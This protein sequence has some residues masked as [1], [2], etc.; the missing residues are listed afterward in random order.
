MGRKLLWLLV[1]LLPLSGC[2][3]GSYKLDPETYHQQVKTLGVVPLLLDDQS[4]ILHPEREAVLDL[5]ARQNTGKS[6]WLVE[7]L[8]EGKGYFDVRE[9]P[10]DPRALF[11]S[12]V[13]DSTIAGTGNQ[14]HRKY[15][16]AP[17]AVG[18]LCRRNAVDGILVVILNGV[19]RNEKHWDRDRASLNFLQTD[20]NPVLASAAVVLP[21]GAIAWTNGGTDSAFLD[22]QY[23]DF[24]EAFYNAS[25]QV[26]L[27]FVSVAGLDRILSRRDSGL[28]FKSTLS[29]RYKELFDRLAN[30]LT[31]GLFD[32]FAPA[33]GT[34]PAAK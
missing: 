11:S 6:P 34:A 5:L 31:P 28:L 25:E 20:Y 19:V 15:T 26:R 33:R 29:Q 8:R 24:D 21:S 13:V 18:E 10:G 30:A 7:A 17:G 23:P 12:L 16:F 1:L 32:Q 9:V 22:L 2:A 3:K 4:T 27:R 14:L